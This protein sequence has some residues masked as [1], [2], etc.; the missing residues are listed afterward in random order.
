[1]TERETRIAHENL[2]SMNEGKRDG[3][4]VDQ[5]KGEREGRGREEARDHAR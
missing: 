4:M 5:R 3:R 1:M 2:K